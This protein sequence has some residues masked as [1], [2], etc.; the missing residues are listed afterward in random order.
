MSIEETAHGGGVGVALVI[1]VC[2]VLGVYRGPVDHRT[3]EGHRA[4]GKNHSLEGR[5]WLGRFMDYQ[6]VVAKRHAI[7]RKKG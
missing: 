2:M 5:M 6:S 4:K 1:G 7:L 3:L